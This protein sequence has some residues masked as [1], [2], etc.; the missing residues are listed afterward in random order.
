MEIRFGTS[1]RSSRRLLKGKKTT[2]TAW[3]KRIRTMRAKAR[4][5]S[6]NGKSGRK[7]EAISAGPL[8][9]PSAEVAASIVSHAD[10]SRSVARLFTQFG[11]PPREHP[12]LWEELKELFLQ[13][14]FRSP[15][16]YRMDIV[17]TRRAWL[18][19]LFEMT[20]EQTNS[21]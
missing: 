18:A 20:A 13:D 14:L 5:N 6:L 11:V 4:K 19:R 17:A 10:I 16:T 9:P 2:L 7:P 15:T 3:Q 8:A 21:R 12:L 1:R